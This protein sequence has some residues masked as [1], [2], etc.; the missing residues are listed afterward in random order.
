M[1][2]V[3]GINRASLRS[4]AG[5]PSS[6]SVR[7]DITEA[8]RQQKRAYELFLAESPEAEE[9]SVEQLEA[10][11]SKMRQKIAQIQSQ[12]KPTPLR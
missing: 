7:E 4:T 8:N 3:E 6:G 5:L 9:P 2:A 1:E 11:I 12:R 10:E